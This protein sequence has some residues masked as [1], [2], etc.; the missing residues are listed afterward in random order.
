MFK[1]DSA[2]KNEDEVDLIELVKILWA[3]K[4]VVLGFG[5][6]G[7]VLAYAYTY[8]SIVAPMYEAKIYVMPPTQSGVIGFNIGRST[9][10]DSL[11]PYTV[12]DVY[13]V[14]TK[15]L[16]G[17]ALRQR[18]FNEVYLPSLS[19]S[20]RTGS[21][22]QLYKNFTRQLVI[23]ADKGIPDRYFVSLQGNNSD[24]AVAWV[25]AYVERAGAATKAEIILNITQE[26]AVKKNE[27]EREIASLR[28]AAL[29]DRDDRI[30][31]LREALS[32]AKAIGL[33][34]PQLS[35]NTVIAVAGNISEPFP[36]WRGSRALTAEINV[37]QSRTSDDAFVPNLRKLQARH[38]FLAQLN[39]DAGQ[40]SVSR[41][42][43]DVEVPSSPVQTK[44]KMILLLGL[45]AG[46]LLGGLLVLARIFL[47]QS[48]VLGV[49]GSER[50]LEKP[51][52]N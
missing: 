17:G 15:N 6:L 20:P 33:V 38:N 4:F 45:I 12:K 34:E 21:V 1:V 25:K 52:N 29:L 44:K 31:Q 36:Y 5:V 14:F 26:I 11:K 47:F 37:L 30:S 27:L 10:D 41:Q 43:G 18:F 35:S 32:I 9:D 3:Q 40:V 8:F 23:G 28:E 39:V 13:S 51:A 48:A 22:D 46:F 50:R 2:I 42:D 16:E 19:S 7:V 49:G 24:Q